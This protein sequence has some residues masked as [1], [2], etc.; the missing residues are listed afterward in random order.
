MNRPGEERDFA[1]RWIMRQQKLD[2]KKLQA[3][4]QLKSLDT[5]FGPED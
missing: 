2:A 1:A 3:A 4:R 5:T